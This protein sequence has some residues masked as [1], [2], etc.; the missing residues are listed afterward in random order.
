[1]KAAIP[2]EGFRIRFLPATKARSK[3]MLPGLHEK[4]YLILSKININ[5]NEYNETIILITY[6]NEAKTI[7]KI[8]ISSKEFEIE[9]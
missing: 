2:A 6:Y 7:E 9:T 8:N 5:K 1:M 4:L 3:E